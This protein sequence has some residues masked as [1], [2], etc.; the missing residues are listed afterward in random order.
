MRQLLTG[1]NGVDCFIDDIVAWGTT[2]DEHDQR[3]RQVLDKCIANGLTLNESK[4]Q[5]RKN[6]VKLFG[7]ILSDQG[8][9][10]DADEIQ[11]VVSMERPQNKDQL[12]TFLGMMG[13][14]TKFLPE[15]A[16]KAKP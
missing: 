9:T 7:H 15:F 16:P 12:R 10:A 11:A 6:E 8:L 14:L 4:C 1:I 2:L 13:Y 5:L 3:L